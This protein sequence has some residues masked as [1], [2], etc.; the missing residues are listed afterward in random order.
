MTHLVATPTQ[1]LAF[2]AWLLSTLNTACGPQPSC[3]TDNDCKG[4]RVCTRGECEEP[5]N[6]SVDAG[7]CL[8]LGATCKT[9]PEC[10]GFAAGTTKCVNSTCAA[11]CTS[12]AQ[13]QTGCCAPL[14]SGGSACGPSSLCGGNQTA[15]IGDP[16]NSTT[17]CQSG[18]TCA[19]VGGGWCTRNC[20][21]S[22]PDCNGVGIDGVN[23]A[24]RVNWC[25]ANQGGNSSCFPSCASNSDCSPFTSTS[26]KSGSTTIGT[27][28]S[29]CTR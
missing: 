17:D 14:V 18:L 25:I 10:C 27:A 11:T 9:P 26:C 4:T 24:G 7:V 19:G 13:C 21:T 15:G 2:A 1:R 12:G 29:A 22:L 20:T 23:R 5:A 3:R 28:V 6:S 8:P 16:C